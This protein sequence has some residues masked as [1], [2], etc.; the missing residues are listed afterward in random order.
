MYSDLNL[1]KAFPFYNFTKVE[2]GSVI[3]NPV[4]IMILTTVLQQMQPSN[5]SV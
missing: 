3:S 5:N 4:N 1:N 2:V